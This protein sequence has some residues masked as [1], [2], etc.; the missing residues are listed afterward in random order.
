MKKGIGLVLAAA[1]I[2]APVASARPSGGA[3]GRRGVW[4]SLPRRRPRPGLALGGGGPVGH[5]HPESRVQV[6]RP[7]PRLAQG[8]LARAER[9]GG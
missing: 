4:A 3:S 7:P 9:P 8:R 1:I 6:E 2:G 5:A